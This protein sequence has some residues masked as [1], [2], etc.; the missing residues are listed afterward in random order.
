[1]LD[2]FNMLRVEVREIGN[3][4]MCDLG[5]S[6]RLVQTSSLQSD[7]NA[8]DKGTFTIAVV[9]PFSTG[10]STFINALMGTNLLSMAVTA[11]TAVVTRVCYGDRPRFR[12]EYEGGAIEEIPRRGQEM[13]LP[14]MKAALRAITT[15]RNKK[16]AGTNQSGT[17]CR[18]PADDC[19]TENEDVAEVAV[20]WDIGMLQGGVQIVDTPGLF[21]R[22]AVH[23]NIT[24]RVLP[25]AHAVI[26]LVEPTKV[27]ES[28]FTDEIRH[29][30]QE[31]KHSSLDE[32]SRH[33][34][35]LINRL[36]ECYDS[37]RDLKDELRETLSEILPNP[38]IM[39][40]SSY[41]ALM[42]RRFRRR[43]VTLE[44]LQRDRHLIMPDPDASQ[45][46]ISGRLLEGRH[47][48]LL[49]ERSNICEVEQVLGRY[50]ENRGL[51]MIENTIDSARALCMKAVEEIDMQEQAAHEM[52]A[53]TREEYGKE[54]KEARG[55]IKQLEAKLGN[56]VERIVL[57]GIRGNGP[58]S[59][60]IRALDLIE[61]RKGEMNEIVK[62]A[63]KDAWHK[64]RG[65][66]TEGNAKKLIKE[67]S[68]EGERAAQNVLKQTIRE[69]H[70]S[71]E[72]DVKD[73]MRVVRSEFELGKVDYHEIM[74]QLGL[75]PEAL[76]V[77][78]NA[79]TKR[80][81]V[82]IESQ[83]K[84]SIKDVAGEIQR[85]VDEVAEDS[86]TMVRKPGLWNWLKDLFGCGEYITTMDKDEFLKKLGKCVDEFEK[87]YIGYLVS[88]LGQNTSFI[89]N[90][91]V[92]IADEALG[93]VQKLV[94]FEITNG[95]RLLGELEDRLQ[96][97]LHSSEEI[98][99]KQKET[100][101]SVADAL[102]RLN[103]LHDKVSKVRNEAA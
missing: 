29:Y 97:E 50:L 49:E 28:H 70:L 47:V 74:G 42:A 57:E 58:E 23:N 55:H 35:F 27:G 87:E 21:S 51:Y 7:L 11:E 12:V 76:P 36:D 83:F 46:H 69:V 78:L 59:A 52:M 79:A 89:Q 94:S 39:G 86:T 92:A 67:V 34:F 45:Y 100:R 33:I 37:Y 5:V 13:D 60:M 77:D 80:I 85:T 88:V 26:F 75:H 20:E 63:F 1:M 19:M 32:K 61:Q 2:R 40:V 48:P 66:I 8:L 4:I 44:D 41:F 101:H 22:H 31:A 10:K 90:S 99:R 25:E 102:E 43:E 14:E 56:R 91:I 93:Q 103:V 72:E 62:K 38:R 18:F 65:R 82:H 64:R 68:F 96:L 53:R 98:I 17:V 9:A 6:E 81:Q 84:E 73:V 3:Y 71:I 95:N 30:V 54:I 24:R 16:P 15:V